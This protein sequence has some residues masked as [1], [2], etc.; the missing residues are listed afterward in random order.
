MTMNADRDHDAKN[1][2]RHAERVDTVKPID[3]A[4]K[5]AGGP[6]N[7]DPI[8]K[9]PGAHP[10]GTGIGAVG[11]GL[12]GAAVGALGGPI[13]VAVG[14]VAGAVAGGLAGKAAAEVI[15]PTVED[16][17]WEKN[18]HSR[19]YAT[20]TLEYK[21]YRPAYQYGWDNAI[22]HEGKPYA[23]FESDLARDWKDHRADSTLDW[24]SAKLAVRDAWDRV[25][26]R[27]PRDVNAR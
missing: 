10:V 3:P 24:N 27:Q 15:D 23:E 21:N 8:T 13:G 11:G 18:F 19:P 22:R 6:A 26:K 12:A 9:T 14:A 7:R 2:A 25:T 1:A 16:A 17:Y 5:P 20:S 4:L